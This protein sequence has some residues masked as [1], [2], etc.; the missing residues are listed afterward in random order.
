LR[1]RPEASVAYEQMFETTEYEITLFRTD[2]A[3]AR[4][5]AGVELRVRIREFLMRNPGST[6]AEIARA[7]ETSRHDVNKHLHRRAGSL[8]ATTGDRWFAIPR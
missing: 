2:D 6:A 7:L 8:F 1:F 3:A 5:E 4:I